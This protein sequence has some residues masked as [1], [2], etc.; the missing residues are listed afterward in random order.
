M[1]FNTLEGTHYMS[2]N[3]VIR[4]KIDICKELL[5][6]RDLLTGEEFQ[7]GNNGINSI[8]LEI[9]QYHWLVVL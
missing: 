3:E 5:L 2:K 8:S 6:L 9:Y 4:S 7:N 1:N